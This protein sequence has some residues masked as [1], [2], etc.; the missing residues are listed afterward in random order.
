MV[1]WIAVCTDSQNSLQIERSDFTLV[2]GTL[3]TGTH[4]PI[5]SN[6]HTNTR[7][8]VHFL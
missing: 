3:A 5:F 1:E 2:Y 8:I 7:V 4:L 6:T